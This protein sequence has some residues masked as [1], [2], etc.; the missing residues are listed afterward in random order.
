MSRGV[1][2]RLWDRGAQAA[3][4]PAQSFTRIVTT[5][6]GISLSVREYGSCAA[7]HTVILK[8][9]GYQADQRLELMRKQRHLM[10]SA[11]ATT[12]PHDRRAAEPG[13]RPR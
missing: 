4:A 5:S 3:P 2:R 13:R 7:R 10:L 6:D 8:L 1:I 11:A 9:A 12:S